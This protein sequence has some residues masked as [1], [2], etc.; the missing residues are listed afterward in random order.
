M[1]LAEDKLKRHIKDLLDECASY[2]REVSALHQKVSTLEKELEL[3]KKNYIEKID[4]AKHLQKQL[5]EAK[6][7]RFSFGR[8]KVYPDTFFRNELE[9]L[10]SSLPESSRVEYPYVDLDT[11]KCYTVV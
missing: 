6:N 11:T 10:L 7:S 8:P 3:T 9:M 2:R 5:T 1:S 4:E